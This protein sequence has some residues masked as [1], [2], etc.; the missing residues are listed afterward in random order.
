MKRNYP[1]MLI[2]PHPVRELAM[3]N[4]KISVAP[5]EVS[6]SIT[7]AIFFFSTMELMATQP[8][9]SRV[10]T[11]GARLPG[12]IFDAVA[13]FSRGM[14]YWQRTYLWAAGR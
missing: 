13:S 11:V 7:V 8:A 14:L 6:S 4:T 2:H 9:S 1:L 10:V 5:T 3:F 12:V